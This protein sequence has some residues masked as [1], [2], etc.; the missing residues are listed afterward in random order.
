MC[1]VGDDDNSKLADVEQEEDMLDSERVE[2]SDTSK[3]NK[4]K[5]EHEPDVKQTHGNPVLN[6][7][8]FQRPDQPPAVETSAIPRL[9]RTTKKRRVKKQK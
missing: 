1:S 4:R 5:H 6:P 2:D 7:D 3:G 8:E 9:Q